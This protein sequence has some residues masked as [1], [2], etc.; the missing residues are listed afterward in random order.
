MR[1]DISIVWELINRLLEKWLRFY[2]KKVF[3]SK[4]GC[5]EK[6]LKILGK[7]Y[8]NIPIRKGN[9]KIGKNVTIYPGVYFWGG[10]NIE[11]GDNVT[12]GKDTI[13]YSSCSVS[14]GNHVNIAAQTYII[15]TDHGTDR[16]QKI[17]EQKDVAAPIFI[18]DDVWIAANCTILKGSNIHDGAIIGAKGLVNGE[19]DDYGIAV[20]I[21][22]KVIKYR[23]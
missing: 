3:E 12:I 21:P 11:I 14:I 4:T 17:Y 1:K 2:R 20:G 7:V 16:K 8:L 15:D 23:E 10:G 9:L 13:I 18:G 6:T 22:A 5:Y 19:I